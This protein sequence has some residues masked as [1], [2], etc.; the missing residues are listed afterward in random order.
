[1]G[2]IRL[3]W[4]F[5][6]AR[7]RP[8]HRTQRSLDR[9]VLP[10][11]VVVSNRLRRTAITTAKALW[12]AADLWAELR[13]GPRILIYH[14]IDAGL[15]RQM[16]VTEKAFV[17]QLDWM[18]DNGN[19][20]DL[21]TALAR[22]GE[23]ESD[24]FF[25]LTFDDGYLDFYERGWPHLQRRGLPFV[26][27]VATQPIETRVSLKPGGRADPPSWGQIAAMLDS[28]LVTVGAHTH[29]H[30]DLRSALP[31]TVEVELQTSDELIEKRLGLRP[32]HF[33]Y[34]GGYWSTYAD[35][36]VRKRYESAVLGSGSPITA[37]SDPWLL[38]R[39]PVQLSD[40]FAVFRRKMA[41]GLEWEDRVRRR[42]NR[43]DG[44]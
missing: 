18:M 22:R 40:W 13:P 32:R 27:Y 10:G 35:P 26:L 33:A 9:C 24:G 44:P 41:T 5:D 14:Q 15:G 19:V 30:P 31:E 6:C 38:N 28:G 42:L 17:R 34:P 29:T 8:N 11:V 4:S 16:E 20:V 1:M 21:E 25:V 2:E 36:T 7:D 23:L 3:L 37:S 39:V 43:Y 12:V